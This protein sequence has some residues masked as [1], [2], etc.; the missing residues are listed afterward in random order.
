M[1][2]GCAPTPRP[3]C[4]G[5]TRSSSRQRRPARWRRHS[6]A[7]QRFRVGANRFVAFRRQALGSKPRRGMSTEAVAPLEPVP[8]SR[9]AA[10]AW[11]YV[12]GAGH[13]AAGIVGPV[14]IDAY[15]APL[16]PPRPTDKARVLADGIIHGSP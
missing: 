8:P 13:F 10:S 16:D 9:V 1:T 12:L 14:A 3:T 4:S 2:P 5:S 6:D 15:D 7:R 11:A